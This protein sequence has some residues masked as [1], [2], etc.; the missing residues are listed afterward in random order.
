MPERIGQYEIEPLNGDRLWIGRSPLFSDPI[1]AKVAPAADDSI[2]HEARLISE[3]VPSAGFKLI[4]IFLDEKRG[5]AGY[6]L[7]V[8]GTPVPFVEAAR[9]RTLAQALRCVGAAL[10]D[11]H[12]SGIA[13]R[14][15]RASSFL[16]SGEHGIPCDFSRSARMRREDGCVP[17]I[18]NTETL[19][20]ARR[21][22]AAFDPPEA[23]DGWYDGVKGD[24]YGLGCLMKEVGVNRTSKSIAALIEQMLDQAPGSRPPL[25]AVLSLVD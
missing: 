6:V 4:D 13:Y 10:R 9:G 12:A 19:P 21:V 5:R 18:P 22:L 23:R 25:D 16:I 15:F 2:Y 24:I 8:P 7:L 1:V 17:A 20:E 3:V 11:V 14:S